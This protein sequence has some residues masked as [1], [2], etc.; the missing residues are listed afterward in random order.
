M[1]R[2][3]AALFVIALD[4]FP[5]GRARADEPPAASGKSPADAIE[6]VEDVDVTVVD[7]TF[8]PAN[9]P[10]PGKVENVPT[11]RALRVHA[12]QFLIDHRA[13]SPVR[14]HAWQNLL[15]FDAGGLKIGLG[16]RFGILR[17]LE[18]GVY[19]LNNA[20]DAFDTYEFDVKYQP[21][22]QDRHALD[23]AV[24]AG[25]T[26]FVQTG[27]QDAVGGFGQLLATRTFFQ[28]RLLLSG[29]LM[30]HSSSSSGTKSN[31]DPSWSLAVPFAVEGKVL[32][33]LA[34]AAEVSVPVAGY[35]AKSPVFTGAVRF[36]TYRH[37]FSLLVTN[38]Q[39]IAADGIVAGTDRAWKDL[40]VGFNVTREFQL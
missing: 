3:P 40:I 26:W 21:L 31:L 39:H 12:F 1:S 16:L 23:V 17:G 7:P 9:F 30:F 25:L 13:F 8:D 20:G 4:L 18:A 19:R 32:R 10:V 22:F 5:A 35:R 34:L 14:E 33:W 28:D 38:S 36:L 2:V 27:A 15:G 24:R 11:A 37:A 6:E 29:G